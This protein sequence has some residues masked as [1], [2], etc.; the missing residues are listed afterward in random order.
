MLRVYLA[1]EFCDSASQLVGVGKVGSHQTELSARSPCQ[2]TVTRSRDVV[3]YRRCADFQ[4]AGRTHETWQS[5]KISF[6]GRRQIHYL[7]YN[8]GLVIPDIL[9]NWV[10]SIL[11]FSAILH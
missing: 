6:K 11:G 10:E 8:S 3:Q 7:K 9:Y 4:G 5:E 1:A 2:V